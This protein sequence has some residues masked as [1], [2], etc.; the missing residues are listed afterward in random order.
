MDHFYT[1]SIS[2]GGQSLFSNKTRITSGIFSQN[3]SKKNKICMETQK[4]SNS[5]S[6]HKKEK[7]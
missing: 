6:N 5:Q 4:T 2:F 3:K 7:Q 1:V